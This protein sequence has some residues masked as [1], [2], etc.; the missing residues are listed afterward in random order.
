MEVAL[1]IRVRPS[2]G[3]RAFASEDPVF[4]TVGPVGVMVS[5]QLSATTGGTGCVA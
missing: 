5:P 4:K 1:A 3:L 2:V